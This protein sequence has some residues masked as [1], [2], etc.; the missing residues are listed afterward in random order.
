MLDALAGLVYLIM[1]GLLIA[2]VPRNAVGWILG[3]TGVLFAIGS[4]W[5]AD[6]IWDVWLPLI[7]IVALPLVF[8]TGR[9]YWRWVAWAG[10]VGGVW[11]TLG[12]PEGVDTL[13]LTVAAIG[14][15]VS[16]IV[17]FRR[18]R[19]VE[20]QQLKWFAYIAGLIVV[21]LLAGALADLN[22]EWGDTA[23]QLAGL[24]FLVLVGFGLPLATGFAVLRHR[25]YD[26]DVVIKRTL[27]YTTLT[28]TLAVAY[29]A[30]V[31]L[32]QLILSPSSDVAI[33]AST[34]AAAALFRPARNRIQGFVDR[35]FF[36]SSYDAA[37]IVEAFGARLR[38]EVSL[39]AL[40]AELRD[41]VTDT[42][43][44]EHVSLWLR[45]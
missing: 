41:V 40:S 20:R 6:L 30:S 11:A 26:I 27:V 38:H 34:L 22:D 12:L 31:L 2:R 24:V 29:L 36:R 16:M 1:G 37:Q 23:A 25:L 4:L 9:P 43:H 13:L 19:G 44:P 18:S 8:P 45:P 39:E 7:V 33:A 42:M 17:R 35:R 28:A 14:A 10:A 21:V 3:A 32:L 5:D 15:L